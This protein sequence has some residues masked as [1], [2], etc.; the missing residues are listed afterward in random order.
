MAG[1]SVRRTAGSKPIGEMLK[2][3]WHNGGAITGPPTDPAVDVAALE[4]GDA[5][6]MRAHREVGSRFRFGV[7]VLNGSGPGSVT[8]HRGILCRYAGSGES[9]HPPIELEELQWLGQASIWKS[10]PYL[11]LLRLRVAG[12]PWVLRVQIWDLGL[13][14]AATGIVLPADDEGDEAGT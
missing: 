3:S 4:A 14:C 2:W 1:R 8:W 13:F 7:L 5:L 10:R 11:F 9:L 12:R 6:V